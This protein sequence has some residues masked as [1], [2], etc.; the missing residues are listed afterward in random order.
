MRIHSY[1]ENNKVHLSILDVKSKMLKCFE[2]SKSLRKS[3][4]FN[5]FKD[6]IMTDNKS[7]YIYGARLEKLFKAAFPGKIAERSETLR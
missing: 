5:V 7:L 6:A 3:K 1:K 4:K 2:E